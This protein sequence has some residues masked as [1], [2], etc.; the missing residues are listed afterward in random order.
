LNLND[1]VIKSFSKKYVEMLIEN[2][3]DSVND[4]PREYLF[5]NTNNEPYSEKS[6]QRMLYDLLKEKSIGVNSLRSSYASYWVPTCNANQV[7]RI[8]Y[9]M[10]T[11]S[12]MLYSN[13]L[14]KSS[15]PNEQD[16]TPK[17]I[18]QTTTPKNIIKLTN[19]EKEE[20]N[21][22]RKD[23]HKKYYENKK[24]VLLEKAREND[25]AKYYLR[26]VRELNQN[27]KI[28]KK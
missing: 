15:E 3:V 4:Y 14:K 17:T 22:N 1:D 6:L 2:I 23:Y 19:E 9:L 27:K 13:Y 21:N 20:Y 26:I 7:Q 16:E 24:D 28:L 10:R 5:I 11:S 25:K 18:Q 12:K 8:A